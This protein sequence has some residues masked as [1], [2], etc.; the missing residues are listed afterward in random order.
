M[1]RYDDF[2]P[3]VVRLLE[4]QDKRLAAKPP[5]VGSAAGLGALARLASRA[6]LYGLGLLVLMGWHRAL[7]YANLELGWFEE[8]R[9]YWVDEL[10]NRPI[11]PHD[12][13]YLSGVY[14][15]RL[16]SITPDLSSDAAQLESWRDHRIVYYL[17][18]HTYRQALSPLRVQRYARFIPRG[19]RV[20][21][22]G[23]GVAPIVTGLARHYRHL[24]L[25]LVAADIPHLLFHFV[26]WRFRDTPY[27]TVMPI[28]PGDDAPLPG[29]FDVI[30]CLE[31]LEH[32]PR[33]L[34]VLGHFLDVL[35]PGGVL[36]FDFIRSEGTHLDSATALAERD[37][38]LRFVKDRFELVEGDI[39]LDG[40][41]VQP[42]VVRKRR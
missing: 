20:A 8:F 13:Y 19:A 37:A 39:P 32:V 28:G 27:V 7:V 18:A 42:V 17:F 11:Q 25:E 26:R 41:H 21:E 14:R 12:F 9:R 38:A 1:N 33:P 3:V 34:A 29:R 16:Q 2:R 22:Y 40:A 15:Q 24:A 36:V 4:E 10:G 35:K 6:R 23:C 5:G 31:V 30:F